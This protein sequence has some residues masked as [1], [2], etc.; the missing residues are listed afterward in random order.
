MINKASYPE[1]VLEDR[2][3]LLDYIKEHDKR[4]IILVG[5]VDTGKTTLA[6]FLIKNLKYNLI[7]ADVGQ[8]SILP[9]ATVSLGNYKE[10]FLCLSEIK[11]EKSYFI[12]STNPTQFIGE[13][14]TGVKKLADYAKEYFIIDTTGLINGAGEYLKKMKIELVEPDLIVALQKSNELSHI[15]KPFIDKVDIFYIK[16]YIGKKYSREERKDIRENKWKTYF[17]NAKEI[18]INFEDY[19]ISGSK[20]FQGERITDDEKL[21][22]ENIYKWEI[23]YGSKCEGKFFIVKKDVKVVKRSVDKNLIFYMEPERFNNLVVGLIDNEGFCSGLAIIKEID[24]KNESLKLIT[25]SSLK[26]VREIRLGR[27]KLENGERLI[28]KDYI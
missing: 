3:E 17:N 24:F 21:L 25:P 22:L 12:G 9:P 8:K 5:G 16:P 13:M 18:E 4:K 6:T 19:I 28:D 26:N 23:L 14:L 10:G 7:D 11:E 27:V 2:F 20:A 1:S 15:L